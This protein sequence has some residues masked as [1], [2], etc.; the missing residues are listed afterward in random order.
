MIR[1]RPATNR[2]G[3]NLPSFN[4]YSAE[5]GGR[6]EEDGDAD[7]DDLGGRGEGAVA[8]SSVATSSVFDV[9]RPQDEQKATL[10]ANSVPQFVHV[11]I[12]FSRYSLTQSIYEGVIP[13]AAVLQA[14]Q[15]ISRAAPERLTSE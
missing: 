9:G 10:F 4:K 7:R 14:E 11:A 1:Y 12:N 15:G 5:L 3:K 8:K 13:N 2:P 6:D